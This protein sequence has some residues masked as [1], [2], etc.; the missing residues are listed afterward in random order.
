MIHRTPI[1]PKDGVNIYKVTLGE[2][3]RSGNEHIEE[4]NKNIATMIPRL[5]TFL[6]SGKLV[7]SEYIQIGDTGVGEV[8]KALEAFNTHKSGKKIIVRLAEK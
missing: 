2:I 3:G 4:V 7:P 6:E 1:E 5:E 8:L